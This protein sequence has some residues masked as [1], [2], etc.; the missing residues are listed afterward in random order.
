MKYHVTLQGRRIEVE[1]TADGLL[2]DGE[3]VAAE[4][5]TVPGTEV[6][7]LRLGERGRTLAAHPTEGGWEIWIGGRRL[8][9]RVEDERA[10]ALRELTDDSG[11][12]AGERE[13]RA[14]M[15]GLVVRV[16]VES[17]QEVAAGDGLVVM[18]A[19]KMENELSAESPGTVAEVAVDEG[20]TVDQ[21]DL[22]VRL[23]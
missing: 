15:P 12:D 9:A 1:L 14:P 8:V 13:L 3:D 4:L 7:H 20:Q 2:L 22:L 10:H 5:A 23:E 18:E 19:M 21:N 17:G 11:R 6:R 16:L